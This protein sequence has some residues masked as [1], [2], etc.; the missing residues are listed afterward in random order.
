M[1]IKKPYDLDINIP[2]EN[3]IRMKPVKYLTKYI[4]IYIASQ[5]HVR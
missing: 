3:E 1:P 5:N 2:R 4:N